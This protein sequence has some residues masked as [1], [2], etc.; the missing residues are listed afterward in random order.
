M[1]LPGP[2]SLPGSVVIEQNADVFGRVMAGEVDF[3]DR[4]DRQCVEIC[5]RVEPEVPRADMDVV[6][7]T[8]DAAAGSTGDLGNDSGSGTAIPVAEIGGRVLDQQ[9]STEPLLRLL[10]VPTEGVEARL[11]IGR[12]QQSLR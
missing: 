7:V 10:D 12:R 6:D 2:A 4:I 5:D 11:G 8:E 1:E 9:P 3:A